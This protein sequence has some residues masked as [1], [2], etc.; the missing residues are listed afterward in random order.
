MRRYIHW[1]E[2]SWLLFMVPIYSN[3]LKEQERNYKKIYAIDW[4]LVN[5]NS[6]IGDGSY[7]RALENIVFIHH[8]VMAIRVCIDI[9]QGNT[10]KCELEAIVTTARDFN[11]KENFIVTYNQE[12]DFHEQGVSVKAIPVWKW[13]LNFGNGN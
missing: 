7:S 2:D 11:V 3:F 4:A 1:A 12:K 10:V 5:K 13:M 6:L 9:S 8:P